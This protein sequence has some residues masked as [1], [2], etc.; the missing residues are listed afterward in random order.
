M[1]PHTPDPMLQAAI[2]LLRR[3]P[4]WVILLLGSGLLAATGYFDAITGPELTFAHFYLVPVCL[5]AWLLGPRWGYCMAVA[6]AGVCLLAERMGAAVYTNPQIQEWNL[7]TR[8][9]FFLASVWLL[10]TWRSIGVRLAEMVDARTTELREQIAQREKA[11]NDLRAWPRNC[12]PPKTQ[13]D[14]SW[15]MRF[16]TV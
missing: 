5:I 1:S 13:S 3:Q 16:T 2:Q 8:L 12:P 9:G 6:S 7:L 14:A 11:Q 4:A 10:S 15:L